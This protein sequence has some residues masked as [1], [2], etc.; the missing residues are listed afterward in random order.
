[1][2]SSGQTWISKFDPMGEIKVLK[3][4][5]KTSWYIICL[6]HGQQ[7]AIGHN[8]I[9]TKDIINLYTLKTY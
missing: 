1:M 6:W 5:S 2:I 8:Y 3:Q 9:T 7:V 4:K